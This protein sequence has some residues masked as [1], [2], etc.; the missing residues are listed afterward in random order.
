MNREAKNKLNEIL[1]KEPVDL[2]EDEKGF[3]QARRGYLNERRQVKYRDVL[4]ERPPRPE[5]PERPQRPPRPER[6]ERPQRPP[7]PERPERPENR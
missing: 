4:A 5:R 2:T 7:R 1:G 6:P 3:L